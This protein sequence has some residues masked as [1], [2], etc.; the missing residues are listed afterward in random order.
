MEPECSPGATSWRKSLTQTLYM[1]GML[2][3]SFLFGWASDQ[4][5]EGGQEGKRTGKHEDKMTEIKYVTLDK[6]I[7]NP[8]S[9]LYL[10]H[11][12][13]HISSGLYKYIPGQYLT[14]HLCT[15]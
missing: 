11:V 6:N 5:G 15:H 8:V 2:V 3:G 12:T 13:L 9:F 7:P 14:N 4:V 10:N 1:V